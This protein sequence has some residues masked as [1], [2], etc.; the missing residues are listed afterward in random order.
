[1]LGADGA[2]VAL[3]VHVGGLD[4]VAF[5][6]L[7]AYLDGAGRHIPLDAERPIA[8]AFRN[9]KPEW[10]ETM[11]DLAAR[12]PKLKAAIESQGVSGGTAALPLCV[13]GRA[14]GALALWFNGGRA[15][16]PEDRALLEAIADQCAIA[17]D[18]AQTFAREHRML[19][20]ARASEQRSR[21]LAEAS[22]ML[23]ASLD[24]RVTLDS[25][26]R[27]AVPQLADW[28]VVHMVRPDG[29]LERLVVAHPDP[30]KVDLA[31]ELARRYPLELNAAM[32]V[33]RVIRTGQPEWRRE[34]PS[35]AAVSL[36]R[37]PEDRRTLAELG[38]RSYLCV[39]IKSRGVVRGAITMFH[40][41]SGRLYDENDFRLALDLGQQASIAVD[42]ALLY[43]EARGAIRLRDDFLS[44]A[45]HELKTPL[46]PLQLRLERMLREAPPDGQARKHL[47]TAHRQIRKLAMLV[48]GLLDVT[49]ISAGRLQL[50]LEDVDLAELAR[51]VVA[52]CEPEAAR[53]GS[54]IQVEA[55]VAVIGRWD[56]LRLDQVITNLVSNAI[57]YG[58]G[59]PIRVRV[60]ADGDRA[61]LTVRDEGIGIATADLRRIFE[62]FERAV[63]GRHYGGLGLGLYITRRIVEAL[64]ASIEVESAPGNGSAF[65]V[66]LPFARG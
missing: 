37:T 45:S 6:G 60:W 66:R 56:R 52:R 58:A 7:E 35:D 50:E 18:R 27:L 14:L 15:F 12:F 47:E 29:S 34:I 32:G 49:R 8:A 4:I 39:P 57:K 17:V 54:W 59:K 3:P 22:R 36:A 55:D 10:I 28:C 9:G 64:G 5:T 1:A 61:C 62:R 13:S 24:H 38:L 51:E 11:D 40:A 25:V 20:E 43:Q 16:L 44:V 63:S 33:P 30:G 65:T 19:E 2:M 21:F 48:D 41:E 26:A 23:A 31:A 42:N 53:L 46:T